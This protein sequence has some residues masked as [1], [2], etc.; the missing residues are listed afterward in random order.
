MTVLNQVANFPFLTVV[1]HLK[2]AGLISYFNLKD[3]IFII[4][5]NVKNV[6]DKNRQTK[7]E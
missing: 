5:K 6:E 3:Q 2:V 7:K 4:E 1:Y